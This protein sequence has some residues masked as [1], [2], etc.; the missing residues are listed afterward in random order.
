MTSLQTLAS[1]PG[2]PYARLRSAMIRNLPCLLLLALAAACSRKQPEPESHPIPWASATPA[3][4]PSA[5][6]SAPDRGSEALTT[7][8][9][10]IVW[11]APPDW[12]RMHSNSQVRKGW[13]KVPAISPDTEKADVTIFYFGEH[14]GGDSEANIQRWIGQFGDTK[15][16]NIKRAERSANGMKQTTVEV[17]GTFKGGGMPGSAEPPK[18][19]F[20]LVGAVVETPVGSYF[21]KMSGPKK[22]VES[23]RSGFYA[24]LDSVRKS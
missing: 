15:P 9:E 18:P 6:A 8:A 7:P 2:T 1:A 5:H 22:A 23:A 16:A 14:E 24:L 20:R 13:Y 10:R 12:I 3:P 11:N 17:E 19:N 21:F 4:A